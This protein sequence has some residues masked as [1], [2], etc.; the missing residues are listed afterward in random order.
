MT[1]HIVSAR[2]V[3]ETFKKNELTIGIVCLLGLLRARAI[4]RG[5]LFSV[6]ECS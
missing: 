3:S 6:H 5:R 2:Y 1:S 4:V